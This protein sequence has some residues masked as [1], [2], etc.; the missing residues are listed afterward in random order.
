[1]VHI[2][3]IMHRLL[4]FVFGVAA[5]IFGRVVVSGPTSVGASPMRSGKAERPMVSEGTPASMSAEA[6]AN[7][8]ALIIN[9]DDWG[10]D[11]ATT[12]RTAECFAA[13]SLS[14]VS[15]MVFMEDSERAGEI[16]LCQ[17][18]DAGLHI[19]LTSPFTSH[20]APALLQDHQQRVSRYLQRHRF[21]Q[22]VF[23]PGL[24]GSFEY[25][26][27]SQFD[28]FQRLYGVM[29]QHVDGHHHMHLC[30]NVLLGR[31]LPEKAIVRRS[32]SFSSGQKSQG[33]RLYR[34]F[35]NGMLLRKHRT[36][37]YFFSLP[38]LEPVRL[39]QFV[40]LSRTSI[41]ELETH[42]INPEEHNFLTGAG[43]ERFLEGRKIAPRFLAS[44]IVGDR[45]SS[46]FSDRLACSLPYAIAVAATLYESVLQMI[47][48]S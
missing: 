10:R 25:V 24:A 34:Q 45:G 35:V 31:L 22:V 47:E 23:H 46:G 1:M 41:V 37:D 26:V 3:F 8:G 43:L 9:A 39:R 32:F 40:D 36:T 18:I 7:T 38:P 42:P 19:N 12:D 29:A 48:Y 17:G 21:A 2:A 14:S 20:R 27:K 16:A 33:N 4:T 5:A 6:S 30:A 11:V 28:E 13:G 44:Q 15:A